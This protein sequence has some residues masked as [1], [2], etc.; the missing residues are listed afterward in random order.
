MISF[1]LKCSGGHVFEIWFRSSGDYETQ[2]QAGQILCPTCGGQQIEKAVMAPAVAAKGNQR[3]SSASSEQPQLML[4]PDNSEQGRQMRALMRAM[5]EAQAKA[6]KDSL[7][8]GDKFAEKARAMHYGETDTVAI[9]GTAGI[10]EAR[11]MLDEG[12]QVAPLLVPIVP[13]GQAN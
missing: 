12:L 2:R 3:S 7:W 5:A 4:D 9:H 8:V 6:L 10:E 1:D 13:P 11:E